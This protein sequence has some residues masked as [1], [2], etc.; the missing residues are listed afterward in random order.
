MDHGTVSKALSS[1]NLGSTT[2]QNRISIAIYMYAQEEAFCTHLSC[3]EGVGSLQGLSICV[4]P[5]LV[6]IFR[7]SQPHSL[8][9]MSLEMPPDLPRMIIGFPIDEATTESS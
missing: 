1:F 8:D 4:A 7:T 2:M 6:S 9:L 5:F 3:C